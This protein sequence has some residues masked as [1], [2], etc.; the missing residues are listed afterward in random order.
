MHDPIGGRANEMDEIILVLFYCL[1]SKY[2]S[3][4]LQAVFV[5]ES[6]LNHKSRHSELFSK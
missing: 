5:H 2:I 3:V 4:N 6:Y 1:S